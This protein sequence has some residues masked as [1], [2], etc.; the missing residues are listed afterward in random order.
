VWL[1]VWLA[2]EQRCSGVANGVRENFFSRLLAGWLAAI[3]LV[4]IDVAESK[5][6]S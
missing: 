1:A 3:E 5:F 4:E 6:D 2:V